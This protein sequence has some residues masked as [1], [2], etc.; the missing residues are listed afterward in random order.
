MIEVTVKYYGG[1]KEVEMVKW[2]IK[3]PKDISK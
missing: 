3:N 2:G 1:T